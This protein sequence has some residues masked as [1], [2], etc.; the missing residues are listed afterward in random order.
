[1]GVKRFV[2]RL[3]ER[4][5]RESAY[6]FYEWIAQKTITGK[7]ANE[8]VYDRE[9]DVLV[10]CDACRVDLFSE[11]A[12][13][14]S[15]LPSGKQIEQT[16]IDSVAGSSKEW[17]DRTFGSRDKEKL[18]STAYVTGNPFSDHV[19]D[20]RDFGL[21]DEVW[22]YAWDNNVGSIRPEPIVDRTIQ[23]GRN[24]DY[25]RIIVHL[26]QPH[27]PFL[28]HPEIH[29]GFRPD[30]WG[31]P[32]SAL[33]STYQGVNVWWRIRNGDLDHDQVWM[34]YKQNLRIALNSIEKLR[35]NIEGQ[36]IIS[37]DHGNAIGER[38]VWG[39]PDIPVSNIRKVPWVEVK[40]TD[41]EA[42]Q[43]NI[44]IEIEEDQEEISIE[45]RLS[46]LG[47]KE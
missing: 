23:I 42:Y 7:F 14:Y 16:A 25:D 45:D 44:N 36:M 10:L 37:A 4:G 41:T 9:W 15:W 39:H 3:P 20:E 33:D 11:V 18:Q 30:A 43:P 8:T 21:L 26:M 12:D 34:A 40:A 19:L 17:M 5:L 2:R 46:A 22:R 29:A 32:E 47:Y 31:S 24:E 13:E 1:M 6:I 38:G 27:V 28:D 35:Q